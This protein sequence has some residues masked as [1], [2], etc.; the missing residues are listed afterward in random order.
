MRVARLSHEY[1]NAYGNAVQGTQRSPAE[2]LVEPVGGLALLGGADVGVDVRRDGVRRVAQV[3]RDDLGVR[4]GRQREARCEVPEG[5]QGDAAE[6]GSL[7]ED[8]EAAQH[9]TGLERCPDLGG[10]GPPESSGG[11]GLTRRR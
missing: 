9:A 5:V 1:S 11:S 6:A 4:T 3:L 7:R 10:D 8:L 2:R